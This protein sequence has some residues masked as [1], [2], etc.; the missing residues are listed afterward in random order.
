MLVDAAD[1]Q[2]H[3]IA[4]AQQTSSDV[5]LVGK[6]VQYLGE[7]A[8]NV[9]RYMFEE[10]QALRKRL[11]FMNQDHKQVLSATESQNATIAFLTETVLSE[12]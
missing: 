6:G 2:N 11:Q 3:L 8:N 12:F 10:N 7:A 9:V 1:G 4:I 5:Q